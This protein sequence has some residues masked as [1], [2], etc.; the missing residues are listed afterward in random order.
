MWKRAIIVGI[1]CNPSKTLNKHCVRVEVQQL[2]VVWKVAFVPFY[3]VFLYFLYFSFFF[4]W[5]LKKKVDSRG[6]G[7]WVGRGKRTLNRPFFWPKDLH[8]YTAL[9]SLLDLDL[10]SVVHVIVSSNSNTQQAR[11]LVSLVSPRDCTSDLFSTSQCKSHAQ[12][13]SVLAVCFT[14]RA[15]PT[16]YLALFS[17]RVRVAIDYATDFTFDDL[18]YFVFLSSFSLIRS[19]DLLC[20]CSVVLYFGIF[21]LLFYVY[22]VQCIHVSLLVGVIVYLR[23]DTLFFFLRTIF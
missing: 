17:I 15:G 10:V 2:H 13:Q 6:V 9:T 21:F 20:M 19:F 22:I 18:R 5:K 23:L 4:F 8:L 16:R 14:S 7:G 11:A 3:I 12:C 1:H